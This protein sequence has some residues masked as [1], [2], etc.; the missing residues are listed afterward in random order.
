MARAIWSG[1]LTFG[2]VSVPVELYSATEAHRPVFHQFEKDTTDRIRYQRVNERTADEVEYSDIVKGAETSRG[3]YVMLDQE[4][5]D[6]VA[7]GRSRAMEIHTFVDLDDIDP[8]YFDKT[9][10][11]GPGGEE[12]GKVYALLRSAMGDSDKAAIAS[13][14]MRGK[15]YLAAVRAD[16][17][18]LALETLFFAD[19]I[20][21]AHQ[22][23][24]NLPGRVKL[25]R[26]ELRMARQLIES[27][28]GP[29]RPSDYRDTYTDRVN[30]LIEAKKNDEEFSPADEAP[31]GTKV[32]DLT[33]ALRASVAAAKQKSGRSGGRGKAGKK[34]GQDSSASSAK[35]EPAKKAR[36]AKAAAEKAPAR[37]KAAKR[38]A[39]KRAA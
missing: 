29:W 24:D 14:V 27:M 38:P 25:T 5:L 21:E 37:K 17:D 2:L 9:Y 26:Q 34:A 1:V 11:L 13:F 31:A 20:R 18:L 15:E 32:V 35:S 22:Q 10:Y 3:H 4:E 7:P 36:S 33:E 16:G 19:E 12:A 6:S 23:I 39:R 30:K 8:I 28:A